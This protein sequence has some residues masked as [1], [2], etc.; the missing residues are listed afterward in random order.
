MVVASPRYAPMMFDEPGIGY[1]VRGELYRVD[2]ATLA[3][4]DRLEAIG[5]PGNVRAVL[6]IGRPSQCLRLAYFKSRHLA[7]PIHTPTFTIT[8]IVGS[9]VLR[10][11]PNVKPYRRLVP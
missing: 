7:A 5:M 2:D 10:P 9:P 3:T 11:H 4:L 8:T 1:Q 6:D